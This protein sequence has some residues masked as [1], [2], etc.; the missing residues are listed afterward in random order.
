MARKRKYT[1]KIVAEVRRLRGKGV[2]RKEVARR[3][4]CD[5]TTVSRL[6]HW[7]SSDP[8]AHQT[9]QRHIPEHIVIDVKQGALHL[10]TRN[11]ESFTFRPLNQHIQKFIAFVQNRAR[12]Q[13][14]ARSTDERSQ[15]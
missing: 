8:R 1:P 13:E 15:R 3:L 2:P 7:G 6:F 9:R 4:G 5:P 11:G 10:Y 12:R 14:R